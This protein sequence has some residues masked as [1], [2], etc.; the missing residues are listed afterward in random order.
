M[1]E[2]DRLLLDEHCSMEER[3]SSAR[4]AQQCGREIVS[5]LTGELG[6]EDVKENR[7]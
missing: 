2:G 6:E 1:W 3:S 4:R 5:H 7:E